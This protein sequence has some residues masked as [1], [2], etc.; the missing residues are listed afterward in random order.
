MISACA[1]MRWRYWSGWQWASAWR[2]QA[3]DQV[4]GIQV[5]DQAAVQAILVCSIWPVVIN[6]T[7][8]MQRAWEKPMSAV[9]TT[10]AE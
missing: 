5:A 9:F 2:R 10:S 4:I 7:V 1:E 3:A 6:T 8:G